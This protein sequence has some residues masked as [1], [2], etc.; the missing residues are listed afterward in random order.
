MNVTG[1]EHYTFET[2][3]NTYRYICPYGK[4]WLLIVSYGVTAAAI[5]IFGFPLAGATLRTYGLRQINL[6]EIIIALV[7]ALTLGSMALELLWQ[8]LGKEVLEISDD[9]V[10]IAHQILG[11]GP[12]KHLAAGKIDSLFVPQLPIGWSAL[13][14]RRDYR[15]FNF[16]RGRVALNGGKTLLGQP[17]TYRFGTGLDE[18][19]AA[20]VVAQIL[21]RFPQYR[22]ESRQA[23]VNPQA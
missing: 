20:Q 14:M 15:F 12:S 22:A 23:V 9:G 2:V 4:E 21:S 11:I 10:V 6:V 16:N 8:L 5:I 19:E 1:G 17:V 13:G 3:G 18:G 7:L